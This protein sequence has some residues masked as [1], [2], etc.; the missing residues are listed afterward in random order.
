MKKLYNE[1]VG[2]ITIT[3]SIFHHTIPTNLLQIDPAFSWRETTMEPHTWATRHNKTRRDTVSPTS[4]PQNEV[5]RYR[6][7]MAVGQAA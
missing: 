3:S 4:T 6:Y 1:L 5:N 7:I 2:E